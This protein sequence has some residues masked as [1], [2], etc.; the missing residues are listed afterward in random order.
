MSTFVFSLVESVE[1]RWAEVDKLLEAA[2]AAEATDGRLH[3]AICRSVVVLIAAHF[4]GFV[5]D[6]AKALVDDTN[7]FSNFKSLP[8][9]SKRAFCKAYI[10]DEGRDANERTEK[11]IA[12]LDDLDTKIATDQFLFSTE[13]DGHK[14]PAPSVIERVARNFGVKKVFK[15]LASSKLDDVFSCTQSELSAIHSELARHLELHTVGFPYAVDTSRFDLHE[16]S[17]HASGSRTLWETFLDDLMSRRHRI[18]HG[19]SADN[20]DSVE[21][22]ESTRMKVAVLQ[23]GFLVVT[24]SSIAQHANPA[25]PTP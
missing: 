22:L 7:R 8:T 15:L 3:D 13:N 12:L 24:C 2:R 25:T 5:R 10:P 6:A 11:L 17:E 19:S 9:Q 1:K 4:E 16:P 23:Y 14:N 21:E 18:A 20:N